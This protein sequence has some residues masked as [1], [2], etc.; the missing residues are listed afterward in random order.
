MLTPLSLTVNMAWCIKGVYLKKGGETMQQ[1]KKCQL[2][3]A[4]GCRLTEMASSAG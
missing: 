3:G 2:A 4:A 1:E